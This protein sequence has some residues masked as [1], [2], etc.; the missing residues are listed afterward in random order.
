MDMTNAIPEQPQL[1]GHCCRICGGV[2]TEVFRSNLPMS[3]SSGCIPV[4]L[5]ARVV[6]CERC[7]L[8][9]KLDVDIYTD[10]LHYDIFD[11]DLQADK[12]IRQ[13]GKPDRTRSQLLAD[14]LRDQLGSN[15]NARVL[16]IGCH[17]GAFLSA[18]RE[19]GPELELHGYD[20]DPAYARWVEPVCGRGHYHTGDP[21]QL[22]GPFDACVLIHT[23]E[24]IPHPL[25]IL[26]TIRRWLGTDGVL[27]IV[28]PDTLGNPVDLYTIDHT[29]HF[30]AD[31]LQWTMSQAGFAGHVDAGLIAMELVAVARPAP[32]A[33]ALVLPL[34]YPTDFASLRRF[35]RGLEHLP[36]GNCHVLGTAVVGALVAG[37]LGHR[38]VGFVDESPFR[39]GKTFLDRPVRAPRDVVGETVVL[40]V[41]EHPAAPLAA[42][43]ARLGIKVVN[44]WAEN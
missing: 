7:G 8:L 32:M 9:Q 21:D 27:I 34:P 39:V 30:T 22:T 13:P 41:A 19:R 44:P 23:L 15:R 16:E 37:L 26:Q 18:L 14:L 29:C 3:G 12:I 38:C 33:D 5:S 25:A 31:Q 17:R 35:E 43:L 20:L 40:G 6:G 4:P 10:Y 11:N 24:H 2:V 28:V 42:R 1:S 36:T